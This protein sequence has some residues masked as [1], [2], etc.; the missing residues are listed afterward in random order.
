MLVGHDARPSSEPLVAAFIEGATLAGADVVDLGLAS[1][2]LCY[3]AS[4]DLDAPA[5]MFTASHNPAEY[6]GI[7]LCRAG[8]APIGEDTGLAEIKAM[9]AG[10]L[11]ER[12]ED[13]GRVERRDLLPAFVA[14]VRSFVDVDALRADA[15]RRRHRQRR[16]RPRSCP[17]CSPACRSTSRVLFGELDGTFPNH[18]AD[19]IQLDNLE[20]LQRAVL[21]G[22]AD[23]GLAFDGD[24]DRVVLVDDQAQTGVGVHHHRDPRG[25]DPRPAPGRERSCTT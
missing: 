1:T 20:D 17:R 23:V 15:R 18:P 12:A 2:D 11:L 10:G 22:D 3:F 5:A 19:P 4:G 25:G 16:R 14:H 13:P 21:D 8:A 24:A 9:V 6:N 7:K